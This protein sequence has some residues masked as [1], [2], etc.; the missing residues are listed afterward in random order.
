MLTFSRQSLIIT[1]R[2]TNSALRALESATMKLHQHTTCERQTFTQKSGSL[3]IEMTVAL[4]LLTA[5][6]LFL[7][8]GT[9]DLI[10]PRQWTIRQNMTD[11][12]LTYEEAYAKRVPFDSFTNASSDWHLFSS[13]DPD[14]DATE[15]PLGKAPGG[16]VITGT[17][18]R[19]RI[20][21]DNNLPAHGGTGT[22][23]TN[24]AEME[25]W[26][27]LSVLTFNIG[28]KEYHKSRTVIRTR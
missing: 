1:N 26:K 13:I 7:L 9:L 6:G 24:P 14:A 17:I 11:A 25:T 28:T 20:P 3:L 22:L 27:L 5:I 2:R 19:T 21:D 23:A 18:I 10:P 15:V 16:K 12:Y 8:I 4:G